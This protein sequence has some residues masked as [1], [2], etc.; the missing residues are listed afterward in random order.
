ME[1]LGYGGEVLVPVPDPGE[2]K[3]AF[4][5]GELSKGFGFGSDPCETVRKV[6]TI[7]DTT[8]GTAIYAATLTPLAPPQL[9]GSPMAVPW[10]V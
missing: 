4:D 8:N 10:S 7:S 2:F 1:R 5:G 6:Q 9:I 3:R